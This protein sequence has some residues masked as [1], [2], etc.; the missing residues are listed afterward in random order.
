MGAIESF[1]DEYEVAATLVRAS[2]FVGLAAAIVTPIAT[3]GGRLFAPLAWAHLSVGTWQRLGELDLN[4]VVFSLLA[5]VVLTFVQ[6]SLPDAKLTDAF[7][8]VWINLASLVLLS[9]VSGVA[10]W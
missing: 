9:F 2:T 4:L 5:S 3:F 7:R 10:A 1:R 6:R 8:H